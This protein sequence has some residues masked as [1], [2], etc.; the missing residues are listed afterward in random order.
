MKNKPGT[1]R[2]SYALGPIHDAKLKRLSEQEGR[3]LTETLRRALD[4]LEEK[5]SA[6]DKELSK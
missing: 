1:R 5:E 2:S 4:A 6:R 3:S